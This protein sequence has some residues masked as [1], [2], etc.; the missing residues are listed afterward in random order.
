MLNRQEQ[1]LFYHISP[2]NCMCTSTDFRL[3]RETRLVLLTS[4]LLLVKY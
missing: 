2:M 3:H 1:D 4:L